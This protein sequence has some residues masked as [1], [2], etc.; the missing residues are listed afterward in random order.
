MRD[1]IKVCLD[2]IDAC[3]ERLRCRLPSKEGLRSINRWVNFQKRRLKE[4]GYKGK[5]PRRPKNTRKFVAPEKPIPVEEPEK[6]IDFGRLCL[7]G[8]LPESG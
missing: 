6:D 1:E 2:E 5:V 3:Y 8:E 7:F 4:L